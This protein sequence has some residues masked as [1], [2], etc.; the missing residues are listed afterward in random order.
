[1]FG[2]ELLIK[3]YFG[4]TFSGAPWF[5]AHLRNLRIPI[6]KTLKHTLCR[7]YLKPFGRKLLI[8]SVGSRTT[9]VVLVLNRAGSVAAGSQTQTMTNII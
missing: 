1:M 4:D 2:H 8:T 6:P 7:A 3:V 5:T 9:I